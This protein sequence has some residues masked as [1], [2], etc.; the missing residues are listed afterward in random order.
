MRL[1]L[2]LLLTMAMTAV[3]VTAQEDDA[4]RTAYEALD[5]STPEA[6]VE[7]FVEAFVTQ[8]YPVVYWVFAPDAQDV[9]FRALATFQFERLFVMDEERSFDAPVVQAIPLLSEGL[10]AGEHSANVGT[11][12]FDD[13]MLAAAEFD[14][15]L[16]DLRGGVTIT[17]SQP[18]EIEQVGPTVDVTAE[19]EGVGTVVFRMVRSV[20]GRWRVWAVVAPGGDR[21]TPLWSVPGMDD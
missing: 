21:E 7:T 2:T 6:A 3:A 19:V 8:N 12:T 13:I 18:G 17:G 20:S 4:P 15:F 16:I 9:V 14:A 1:I 11:F 5:L 10:D